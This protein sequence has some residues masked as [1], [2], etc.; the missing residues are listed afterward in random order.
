MCHCLAIGAG[1]DL[2][3]DASASAAPDG[4]ETQVRR[5][6]CRASRVDCWHRTEGPRPA[7]RLIADLPR[8]QTWRRKSCYLCRSSLR[9]HPYSRPSAWEL[10]GR[11]RGYWQPKLGGCRRARIRRPLRCS[12]SVRSFRQTGR[13]VDLN[14]ATVMELPI[15]E[16]AQLVLEDLKE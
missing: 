3:Y 7:G 15:D 11:H 10:V 9:V 14:D 13:M 5:Y 16:L 6:E 12:L 1:T 8:H 4:S 2:A